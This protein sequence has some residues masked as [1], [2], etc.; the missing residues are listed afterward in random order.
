M[1]LGMEILNMFKKN[2]SPKENEKKE[3]KKKKRTGGKKN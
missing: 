1:K 3:Q 2:P